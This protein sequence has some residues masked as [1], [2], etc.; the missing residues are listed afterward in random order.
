SSWSRQNLFLILQIRVCAVQWTD[1]LMGLPCRMEA[2]KRHHQARHQEEQ[3]VFL[4][5][6]LKAGSAAHRSR[7]QGL[8]PV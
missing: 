2:R 6:E 7:S 5:T 3:G 4:Q 8:V 1:S